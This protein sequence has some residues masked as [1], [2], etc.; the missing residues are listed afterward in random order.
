MSDIERPSSAPQENNEHDAQIEA[1]RAQL[2][3]LQ[4]AI[5]ARTEKD[6]QQMEQPIRTAVD[7]MA[8][9]IQNAID[10]GV[11]ADDLVALANTQIEL[12]NDAL[13][14]QTESIFKEVV[15][16]RGEL[17]GLTS[18]VS[19]A[20]ETT[21]PQEEENSIVGMVA[22]GMTSALDI[23]RSHISNMEDGK[24]KQLLFKILD[25]LSGSIVGMVEK[26]AASPIAGFLIDDVDIIDIA[27][28]RLDV[29][30]KA[31]AAF[32]ELRTT[33]DSD[34]NAYKEQ[35]M[36]A[37]R[38]WFKAGQKGEMPTL[39]NTINGTSLAT[40]QSSP[41]QESTAP[42][43][44]AADEVRKNIADGKEVA[45][46]L[47]GDK[48]LMLQKDKIIAQ[49]PN[50]ATRTVK[51]STGSTALQSESLGR[52]STDMVNPADYTV[53]LSNNAGEVKMSAVLTA[54]EAAS[55]DDPVS[56]TGTSISVTKT[57]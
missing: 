20:T 33:Y 45:V 22:G 23:A 28:L 48:K 26:V 32:P 31:L 6:P 15:D 18:A 56:I 54:I 19:A 7:A 47:A 53:L 51:L 27:N 37:Y 35:W 52:V 41:E 1:V 14:Q 24:P 13:E 21:P 5:Q 29:E 44:F 30:E 4:E 12:E 10:A 2:Q 39:V 40:P 46:T 49:L 42:E 36:L 25:G 38:N 43:L 57:I 11:D 55:G 34:K 17:D 50:T 3:D 8:T 9:S 16:Q